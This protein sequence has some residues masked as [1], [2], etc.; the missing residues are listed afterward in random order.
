MNVEIDRIVQQ[1]PEQNPS[2]ETTIKY[3]YQQCISHCEQLIRARMRAGL[4]HRET[5]A[6]PFPEIFLP[7]W[8]SEQ[9]ADNL[10]VI[11]Q[12][13]GRRATKTV[14]KCKQIDPLSS[15]EPKLATSGWSRF[16]YRTPTQ[17]TIHIKLESFQLEHRT[18]TG[19][20]YVNF[21]YEVFK[22]VAIGENKWT[23]KSIY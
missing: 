5:F 17:E 12:A 23:L 7:L 8:I 6:L 19:L 10:E 3:V 21:S 9:N 2:P 16:F 20:I 13:I 1:I 22:R 14:Y 18:D 15:V 11:Q 4:T